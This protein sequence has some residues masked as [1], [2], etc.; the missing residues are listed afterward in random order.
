MA[1]SELPLRVT[2][3]ACPHD[4]PDTCAWTVTVRDG[5]AVELHGDPDHPFTRG[6]LCAKVNHFL[7]DRTYHPDRVLQPLRRTGPKGAGMFEPVA[8]D[9]ALDDIA[10]RLRRIVDERGAQAVMPYSYLGTQGLVQGSAMSDAFFARLG[11]T[12]LVRSVCGSAGGTGIAMTIGDGP[13]F[14]PED[15]AHS[16]YI[17]LWGTNTISTNLHLWPFIREAKEHG[18]TIVAIDPAKT[19]TTAAADVHIRPMPGT[20]AALALGMMHVIVTEGLHDERYLSDHTVGF[21]ELAQRLPEYAPER[22][23][24]ITGI[25]A[26]QIR[27]LARA[28]A[29]T[30]PAAIRLLVG[31]EHHAYGA[32]AF[33]AISCLPA[34]VGAWRD[35]GGGLC[36]MTF[37]L[38]GDI[39]WSCGISVP[40]DRSVRS[41]NMVQ[42]GRALTDPSM[43]PPIGALVV[44][45]SNPA[46]IAPN[47]NLVLEG[48]RR[49][50][51][52][53]VVLEHVLTDTALHA[54]YVLP[55]TTQ[56]EHH[57]VHWSWGQTYLTINEPAIP[58]V[59]DA[60]PNTEIFRRL[61]ARMGFEDAAFRAT[62]EE[63]VAA[64]LTPLGEDRARELRERGWIRVDT[65]DQVLPYADGGFLT[66]S[67]KCE[68]YSE[69]LAS[70]GMDPLPG[71]TPAPE[72][73]AGDPSLAARYPL[74]LLTAKGAHHFL[75]SSYGNVDRALKAEKM[76]TLDLHPDDAAE[77]GIGDGDAVRVF[78]DRGSI[79]LPAKVGDKVRPGVVSMP[80]G[81]WASKTPSGSSANALTPDGISDLGRGGDFHSALV[82]VERASSA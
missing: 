43:D 61:A 29:T 50:D 53:T 40:E 59:G 39:D 62:D 35:R 33:R 68:L 76:P 74:A 27:H 82:Q 17:I 6:G 14:L 2:R 16:R 45:N 7:E 57:D 5:R 11:A 3:G 32:S 8:W 58:P 46:A 4:C 66:P 25:D 38:F 67:G 47:Q 10:G 20:D 44:Y 51:L 55:A 71:F 21:E 69:R 26:D 1:I 34:V 36:H 12:H 13:G 73:P 81:W 31:M 22:V 78:N 48:L 18:A 80:S 9:A 52:F 30:R 75:N 19:R 63:M 64:A 15:L 72:S 60:L 56:V 54:D 42:V 49:E 28:Y 77:R 37:Q 24:A 65:A 23:A 41:V 79:E 70:V